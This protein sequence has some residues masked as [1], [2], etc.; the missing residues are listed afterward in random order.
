MTEEKR[1]ELTI[2]LCEKKK[3]EIFNKE[4]NKIIS[5]YKNAS[6]ENPE[7]KI[8]LSTISKKIWIETWDGTIKV[9]VLMDINN[10]LDCYPT[11]LAYNSYLKLCEGWKVPI[12][13][14]DT[15]S[16]LVV[17]YFDYVIIDK[18]VKGK[19][20]RLFIKP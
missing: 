13:N 17:K 19:K 1:R 12:V 7:E 8:R 11:F 2:L 3:Q 4:I 16:K 5:K 10:L 9:L 18:R 15:F 14:K 6:V 20:Y